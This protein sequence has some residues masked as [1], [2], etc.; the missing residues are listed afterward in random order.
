MSE[1]PSIDLSSLTDI[2]TCILG[3]LVF[4]IMLTGIDAS[5]ITVLVATPKEMTADDK[6]PVFFECRKDQLFEISLDQLKKACDE[7]T[8]EIRDW[9]KGNEQEFLKQAAQTMLEVNGQR[10][11][12]TYALM[13]KYV[14]MPI[15][16]ATGYALGT[17]TEETPDKWYASRL[18]QI[19]PETQFICF[20]VRP[21]SYRVFQRAR[22]LAWINNINVACELQDEKNP[23]SIGPGGER[24]YMQ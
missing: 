8:E 18:A 3:C 4:I 6:S 19:D 15:M 9:V 1:G 10:L 17:A 2:M 20:L 13:G 21:D 11:D 22:N 16:D 5:Q 14:L 7:K 24:M 23:I 12:Y